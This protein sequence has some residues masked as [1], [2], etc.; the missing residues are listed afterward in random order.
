MNYGS[1]DTAEGKK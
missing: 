1:W